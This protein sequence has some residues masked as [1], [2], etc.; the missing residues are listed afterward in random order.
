MWADNRELNKALSTSWQC[1]VSW[2]RIIYSWSLAPRRLGITDEHPMCW[3]QRD[4][5]CGLWSCTR[6]GKDHLVDHGK[7]LKDTRLELDRGGHSRLPQSR[8]RIQVR[9]R[10]PGNILLCLLVLVC[11]TFIYTY[12]PYISCNWASA[13]FLI[14]SLCFFFFL[15]RRA[16]CRDTLNMLQNTQK[17]DQA[18]W[19]EDGRKESKRG[20]YLIYCR[21]SGNLAGFRNWPCWSL[22]L[23]HVCNALGK[24]S[25]ADF[26][27]WLRQFLQHV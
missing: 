12:I 19:I 20:C 6:K 8:R 17:H 23:S 27:N 7:W 21:F 9:I 3:V 16:W 26:W 14:Q 4:S 11:L 18:P 13:C 15:R 5:M 22:Q 24:T 10:S 2:W 1:Q 25:L